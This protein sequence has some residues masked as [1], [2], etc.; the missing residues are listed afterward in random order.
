MVATGILRRLRSVANFGSLLV[1][2]SI[3][4]TCPSSMWSSVMCFFILLEATSQC[5]STTTEKMDFNDG[6]TKP[7]AR[8]PNAY[9]LL[10]PVAS[11]LCFSSKPCTQV[12]GKRTVLLRRERP[13]Y[14][15]TISQ[16]DFRDLWFG[17]LQI[18]FSEG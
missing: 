11:K 2:L 3:I 15:G 14:L 16:E 1:R 7:A 5:L 12:Q 8:P 18:R 4:R 6:D 10:P 9:K 17:V 13:N